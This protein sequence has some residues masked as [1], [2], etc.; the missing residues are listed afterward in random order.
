MA[1]L[2]LPARNSRLRGSERGIL[3]SSAGFGIGG[4]KCLYGDEDR[5]NY[6]L[7][8]SH[9]FSLVVTFSIAL[10]LFNSETLRRVYRPLA[11]IVNAAL[12]MQVLSDVLYFLYYPY[13]ENQ[14]NCSEMFVSRVYIILFM[15]G[16]LHQIYF[17][18]NVLGC[19][20][21]RF[22]IPGIG[23][24]SLENGLR[25]ASLLAVLTILMSIYIP[26]VFM[27]SH[28]VWGLFIMSL[29]LYFIRYA[30]SFWASRTISSVEGE[31]NAYLLTA[32][33]DAIRIFENLTY[34]QVIPCILTTLDRILLFD[35]IF[36]EEAA[37]DGV[38]LI[39]ES[40]VVYLFYVKIIVLKEKA[41][42]V[43]VEIVED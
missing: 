20:Q 7:F 28:S 10:L 26:E 13:A 43:S 27:I 34:L 6:I 4:Y 38:L 2:V 21:Y 37:D 29:Q 31:Q 9:V 42:A 12:A 32:N 15:F 30:R 36:I 14:G 11:S 1:S 25:L 18:A 19:S 3:G 33:N 17:V 5:R 16:E 39:L 8:E 23:S 40:L 24:L 35:R 22:R 41:G